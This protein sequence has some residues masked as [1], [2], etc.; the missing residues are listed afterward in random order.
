MGSSAIREVDACFNVKPEYNF[1]THCRTNVDQRRNL[2]GAMRD[3][4]QRLG[5]KVLL[6]FRDGPTGICK[7]LYAFSE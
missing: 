5:S 2:E 3:G 1:E 6:T 7:I 4:K